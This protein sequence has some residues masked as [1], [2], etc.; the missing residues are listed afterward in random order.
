MLGGSER[1]YD[2][3]LVR[4]DVA[5]SDCICVKWASGWGGGMSWGWGRD[6]GLP[7]DLG[8]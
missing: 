3:E 7:M 8:A 4:G 1:S 5:L 2:S 6:N